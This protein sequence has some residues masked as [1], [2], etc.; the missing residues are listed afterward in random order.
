MSIGFYI[1]ISIF[2]LVHEMTLH[3]IFQRQTY[4]S[5][6]CPQLVFWGYF[7]FFRKIGKYT[8]ALV[9][10]LMS[11]TY[12][13]R[14]RKKKKIRMKKR[15]VY[16]L[17]TELLFRYVIVNKN[18]SPNFNCISGPVFAHALITS[19]SPQFCS[20]TLESKYSYLH[21]YNTD[22]KRLFSPSFNPSNLI[23]KCDHLILRVRNLR[24]PQLSSSCL[25]RGEWISHVVPVGCQ[26]SYSHLK[27]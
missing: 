12:Y 26:S 6:H 19:Q 22:T 11:V 16:G 15:Y 23:L 3:R 7:N 24:Q 20:L 25:G 13:Q 5:L 17:L 8:F 18:Y 1:L 27:T 2:T 14:R 9:I 10:K 4:F 21:F